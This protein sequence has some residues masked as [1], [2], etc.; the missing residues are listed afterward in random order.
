MGRGRADRDRPRWASPRGQRPAPPGRVGERLL[1]TERMRY[2]PFV[3][4]IAGRGA[5]AWNIQIEAM[6]RRD[7]GRDIIFLTV[8]DPD[9]APPA[10]ILEATVTALRAHP[11][12]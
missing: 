4:R 12:G 7:L 9:Q 1:R 3:E 11:T 5:G 8:G 2:S 6:R 10:A